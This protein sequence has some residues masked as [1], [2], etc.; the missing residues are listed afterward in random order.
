MKKYLSILALV[1]LVASMATAQKLSKPKK[2]PVAPTSAQMTTIREGIALHDAKKYD[3]AI[4]KFKEVLAA[5][6]DAT[7]AL[8]ELSLSYYEKGDKA[9]SRETSM[10][11]AGYIADELPMF[12]G[13]IANTLDDEGKPNEAI[14][15][16]RDAED[17]LNGMPD[18]RRHLSSINYNLAITYFRQKKYTE[19]RTEA[20][21][22][23]DANFAYA[24]PHH[25]LAVIFNGTKYKIPAFLA[26]TRLISLE[27][28]TARTPTSVAIVTETLKMPVKD[29]KTGSI[30]LFMDL[31]APTDE[32]DFGMYELILGT[33]TARG[34]DDKNK[35]DNQMFIEGL[36]T[37]ISLLSEDK[38]L[39]STFVGK[40]YVP[41][42]KDMKTLGHVETFG[43]MVL[44]LKDNRNADAAKWINT[45]EAKMA[46]FL[47]WAKKYQNS[48][49]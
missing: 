9:K 39:A 41:F 32:G 29:P 35:T 15:I 34:D 21:K 18:M 14:K 40:H 4:A 23:V 33:V 6:P 25:L 19:S 31:G 24:S 13:L 28:N 16:Y 22:A 17:I 8:Y 2:F 46:A 49:K 30:N 38:K 44:Y 27:Y 1:L 5:N 26:A 10:I 12:Y 43:N 37:V 11:G 48:S 3:E 45:N 7:L 36:G 47:D 20:K 42:M